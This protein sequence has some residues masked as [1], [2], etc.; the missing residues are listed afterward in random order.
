MTDALQKVQS[1]DAL[2]IQAATFNTFVDSA[3]DYLQ[4]QQGTAQKPTQTFRQT[5]IVLVK[6][7]SGADRGRFGVLGIDG[8]ILVRCLWNWRLDSIRISATPQSKRMAS[9]RLLPI[10]PET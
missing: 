8:P 5:G 2:K 1:G 7:N 3:R 10:A 6:N 4:R 9:W